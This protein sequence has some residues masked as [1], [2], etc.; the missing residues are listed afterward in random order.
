MDSRVTG[1]VQVRV[2]PENRR[3]LCQEDAV[4]NDEN[5]K[6]FGF[7][8]ASAFIDDEFGPRLERESDLPGVACPWREGGAGE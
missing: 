8:A 6:L 5:K 7:L 1:Q 4:Q 2:R 3:R